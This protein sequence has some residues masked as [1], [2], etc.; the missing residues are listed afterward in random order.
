ME[1]PFSS[2]PSPY[3]I[4]DDFNSHNQAWGC[5]WNDIYGNTLLSCLE[6]NLICLNDGPATLI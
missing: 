5:E 1:F 2:L 3:V 4:G 6:N